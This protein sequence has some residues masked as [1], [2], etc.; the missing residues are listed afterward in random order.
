MKY[1]IA[2]IFFVGV[3]LCGIGLYMWTRERW[4]RDPRE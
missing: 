2:G 3:W 4:E 1:L